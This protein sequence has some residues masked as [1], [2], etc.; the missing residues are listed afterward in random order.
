MNIYFVYPAMSKG[1]KTLSDF[2]IEKKWTQLT[3]EDDLNS[4]QMLSMMSP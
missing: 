2:I 1:D 3:L 4:F